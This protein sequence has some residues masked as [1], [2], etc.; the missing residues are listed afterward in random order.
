M[1]NKNLNPKTAMPKPAYRRL[2][3]RRLA[4]TVRQAFCRQQR[5]IYLTWCRHCFLC[6]F[7][8]FG[9]LEATAIECKFG[10][11]IPRLADDAPLPRIP[12]LLLRHPPISRSLL[13]LLFHAEV[14]S[15]LALG[16]DSC[17]HFFGR[18][19][20]CTCRQ[21]FMSWDRSL[22]E[23]ERLVFKTR[24]VEIQR[25]GFF[26]DMTTKVLVYFLIGPPIPL[27]ISPPHTSPST[28]LIFDLP[29]LCKGRNQRSGVWLP[30]PKCFNL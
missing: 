7:F 3:Q 1:L 9:V 13:P 23:T 29:K 12:R 24:H 14:P 18:C 30:T 19:G 8:G 17:L 21:H 22:D 26:G 15:K 5:G 28:Q 16:A 11:V 4:V 6:L 25:V 2:S 10:S 20:T 27:Y